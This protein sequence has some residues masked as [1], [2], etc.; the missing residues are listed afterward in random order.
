MKI[1]YF[2]LFV[3]FGLGSI[4]NGQI[5]NYPSQSEQKI[6]DINEILN[7]PG[8][9]S[10]EFVRIKGLVIQYTPANQQTTSFYLL[11]GDFG[12][13]IRVN[14]AQ[15]KPE[16]NA[17]YEVSGTIVVDKVNQEVFLIEQSKTMLDVPVIQT[18]VIEKS[19]FDWKLL[20]LLGALILL[21]VLFVIYL[22]INRKS[23]NVSIPVQQNTGTEIS[24]PGDFENDISQNMEFKTI[25]I[26]Q[27]S[28]KTLKLI[29][30]RLQIVSGLD[31]GKEFPIMATP[32]PEG[33]V[34]KIG[35]EKG[36]PGTSYIELLEK[37]VSRQQAEIL[38][39]DNKLYI[40]NLSTT[41]H[42]RHNGKDLT[43][44]ELAELSSGSVITTGE[45]E[46]KYVL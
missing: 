1:F 29:P 46:F 26:S 21:L 14:T 22:M 32:G 40:R 11:K 30:G 6:L 41:N 36:L 33:N 19:V 5:D 12:G 3:F 4:A 44:G 15:D 42:T 43:P 10:N 17:K 27:E 20:L 13:I 23:R 7:S 8:L 28:P 9:Y 38:F 35:R 25:K 34:L 37:T 2:L 45:V 16:T 24:V 39:K 31:K 18:E